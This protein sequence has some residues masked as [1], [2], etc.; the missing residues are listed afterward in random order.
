MKMTSVKYLVGEGF[1]NAWVNR[2]MSIASVG[3]LMAC[4]IL[5]GLA[6]IFSENI[7]VALGNLEKQKCKRVKR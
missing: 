6:L 4:M 1:K 3:V 7:N 2:L 5:M